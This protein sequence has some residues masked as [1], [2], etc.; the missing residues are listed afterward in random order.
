MLLCLSKKK[1]FSLKFRRR[2]YAFK[3]SLKILVTQGHPGRC[4]ALDPPRY[5]ICFL[6]L[7]MP[8]ALTTALHPCVGEAI[9]AGSCKYGWTY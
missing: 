6:C 5:L 8:A 2:S 7:V 4:T 1:I 3:A 9:I